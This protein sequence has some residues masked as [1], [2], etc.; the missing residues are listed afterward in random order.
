MPEMSLSQPTRMTSPEIWACAGSHAA[1][2]SASAKQNRKSLM[3]SLPLNLLCCCSRNLPG[4]NSLQ[5][6]CDHR[7]SKLPFRQ[8]QHEPIKGLLDFDLAGQ[9]AARLPLG[10]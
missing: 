7:W 2:D 10:G 4:I 1:Q 6:T 3:N 5:D 9:P 8:A